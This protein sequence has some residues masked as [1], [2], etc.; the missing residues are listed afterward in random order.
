[1]VGQQASSSNTN[2]RGGFAG[3]TAGQESHAELL[4]DQFHRQKHAR[5]RTT[6]DLRPSI[7]STDK[8][9]IKRKLLQKSCVIRTNDGPRLRKTF[10]LTSIQT[11]WHTKNPTIRRDGELQRLQ[12]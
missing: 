1:V 11:H 8:S 9:G 5:L 7:A 12:A 2:T 3:S 10:A 4:L 6:R